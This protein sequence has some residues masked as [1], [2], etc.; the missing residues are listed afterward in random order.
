MEK[1]H[2]TCKWTMTWILAVYEGGLQAMKE[3]TK[4][5][6]MQKYDVGLHELQSKLL[7]RGCTRGV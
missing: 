1:S 2:G 4:T 5:R 6:K 3:R 7:K